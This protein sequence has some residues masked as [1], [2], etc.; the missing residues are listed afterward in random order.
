MLVKNAPLLYQPAAN[1]FFV[2]DGVTMGFNILLKFRS[3]ARSGFPPKIVLNDVIPAEMWTVQLCA[4]SAAGNRP[5]HAKLS[6][7]ES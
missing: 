5:S 7:H 3:M 4:N 1:I 2:V 6:E